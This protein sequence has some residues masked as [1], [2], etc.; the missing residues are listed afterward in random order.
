LNQSDPGTELTRYSR[1]IGD[2]QVNLHSRAILRRP[3]IWVAAACLLAI[4]IYFVFASRSRNA[5]AKAT[6]TATARQAVPVAATAA[7]LGDLNLYVSAIGTVTSFNTVTMKTRVDG[8]IDKI[9][10]KE[11]QMVNTGD[12]LAEIDP[13]PFQVQ[14]T[15]AEGQMA[16]DRASLVNARTL[17]ARDKVLYAQDVIARQE[18]DNQ[19]AQVGQ[20]EGTVENDQGIIDSAKLNLIYT[21]ITAPISGR[22]GLRLVDLGNMVHTTDP[23]GLLVITQLQ[24]IA[25]IFSVPEDDLQRI[26]AAMRNT[27]QL[28]VDV[29]DRDFKVKLGTGFLLTT[30]NQIDQTTG[31]IKLKAQFANEDKTMF[32]NQFVN[33]KLLVDKTKNTVIVPAPAVQRSSQGTFVYVVQS[34]Q[35][36]AMRPVKIEATQGERA[37]LDS[38]VK[39]GELVVTDGMDKLRQGSKVAVQLAGN[40]ITADAIQ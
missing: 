29:Y 22:V 32:P 36:V 11:G 30:D 38:G 35:T 18:L 2:D 23:N 3:G 27:S 6:G 13:R 21:K 25:V 9:L 19:R 26:M 4:V 39:P 15:Q 20:F 34:N 12:Q 31:T 28:P 24:P 8:Q 33:T 10:F 5:S 14:L 7:K 1:R 37:A 17:Y 16:R 40:P